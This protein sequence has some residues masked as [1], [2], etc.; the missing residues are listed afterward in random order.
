MMFFGRGVGLLE[1]SR[2]PPD[3]PIKQGS[4]PCPHLHLGG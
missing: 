4:I 3:S 2:M 1:G